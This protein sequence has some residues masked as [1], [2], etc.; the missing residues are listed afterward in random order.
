MTDLSLEEE[1]EEVEKVEGCNHREWK[2]SLL[3]ILCRLVPEDC[4]E[5]AKRVSAFEPLR[6]RAFAPEGEVCNEDRI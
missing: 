5:E 6:Q 3:P 2:N 4:E 1:D